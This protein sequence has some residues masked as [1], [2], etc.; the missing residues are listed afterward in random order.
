MG[1]P[2]RKDG[3]ITRW[4]A[5][6]AKHLMSLLGACIVFRK[7]ATLDQHNNLQCCRHYHSAVHYS[8][9]SAALLCCSVLDALAN[10]LTK[11]VRY[12]EKLSSSNPSNTT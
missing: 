1:P 8:L 4:N 9:Y 5:E 12:A 10:D 3:P 2:S 11:L 6:S 7:D